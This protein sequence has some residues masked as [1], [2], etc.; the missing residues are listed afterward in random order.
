MTTLDPRHADAIREAIDRVNMTNAAGLSVAVDGFCLL[1]AIAAL[2]AD[3]RAVL[4][5]VRRRQEMCIAN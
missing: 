3:L 1:D 5:S 2:Q 4:E